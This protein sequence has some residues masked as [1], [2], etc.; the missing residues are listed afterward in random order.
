MTR[1]GEPLPREVVVATANAGKLREIRAILGER[2]PA[3]RSLTEFPD[4]KLPQ[5]GDDYEANAV[6]KAL[7]AAR[8][9]GLPA[10]AD[11][12]GL[13]VEALGGRPGPRSA[14]FG[15]SH[16]GDRERMAKLLAQLGGVPR[17]ARAARFVCVAAL[18]TPAGRVWTARGECRGRLL[19]APRGQGG[20]GY[21]PVFEPE[22]HQASMAELDP[23]EK[24]R[25]SHRARALH[26]LAGVLRGLGAAREPRAPRSSQG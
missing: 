23:A 16:L 10:L 19:E 7:A 17:E 22:H 14:R 5:E 9:C 21:D 26:D 15:G 13:E 2:A 6:A 3:L 11:D 24:N 4:A 20:F 8:A 18:A 12:S 1:T 25:I